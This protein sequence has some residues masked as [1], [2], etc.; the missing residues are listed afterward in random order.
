MKYFLTSSGLKNDDLAEGLSTLLGK[1][2]SD[3]S[4]L[5]VPTAANTEGGDKRWLIDNLKEF[6]KY[7]FASI[8]IL[9]ISA[10]TPDM[11]QKRMKE[12]DVICVG[13]GN[14][15]Y[16]A[17]VFKNHSMKEFLATLP[18]TKV[19]MGIS[20]GS[21]VTGVLMPKDLYPEIFPEEDFGTPTAPGM[22]IHPFCFIPHLNSSFFAHI[23]KGVLEKM[24]KLF[25]S[26]VYA[27]DDGTALAIDEG[28]IKIVGGGEYWV[29]G[30]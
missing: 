16:L 26:S 2:L 10:V 24:K 12:K 19:Y 6:E 1:P 14:E 8:D 27:L 11:W 5:F 30:V 3:T 21:M 17:E 7:N 25:P 15:V 4:V 22:E 9:D 28:G 18:D 29:K 23:R 13:G 20:A